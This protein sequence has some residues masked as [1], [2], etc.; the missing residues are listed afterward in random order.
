MRVYIRE[1]RQHKFV[2]SIIFIFHR[3]CLHMFLILMNMLSEEGTSLSKSHHFLAPSK[4]GSFPLPLSRGLYQIPPSWW[5]APGKAASLTI[6]KRG[7]TPHHESASIGHF[8]TDVA[9]LGNNSFT[10]SLR[11]GERSKSNMAE[12]KD[13]T[14]QRNYCGCFSKPTSSTYLEYYMIIYNERISCVSNI[15]MCVC[16]LCNQIVGGCPVC[17]VHLL[18][19]HWALGTVQCALAPDLLWNLRVVLSV[20]YP[21]P[22]PG[23][24]FT[25]Q[26]ESLIQL[27]QDIYHYVSAGFH[28]WARTTC[29]HWE[30]LGPQW[31]D[32]CFFCPTIYHRNCLST[33]HPSP[34]VFLP[35]PSPDQ[36]IYLDRNA[37]SIY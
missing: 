19:V 6:I 29:I 26:F 34:F 13:K 31:E 23:L 14:D 10:G 1:E 3:V 9:I 7:L 20:W 25:Q 4:R 8:H 21:V 18:T 2:C 27:D 12:S 11:L 32:A 15:C 30:V 33:P 17:T 22:Q 24:T 35:F 28:L 36:N 16:N 5:L 37:I